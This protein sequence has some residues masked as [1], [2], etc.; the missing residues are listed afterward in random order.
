[1]RAFIK[2]ENK[3]ASA[4]AISREVLSV[5]PSLQALGSTEGVRGRVMALKGI[6]FF[7]GGGGTALE[8]KSQKAPDGF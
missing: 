2:I 1:M 5:A 4:T 7:L 6:S 8:R 3:A